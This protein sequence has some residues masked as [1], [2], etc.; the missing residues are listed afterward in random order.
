MS[1]NG[2]S[3]GSGNGGYVTFDAITTTTIPTTLKSTFT[4]NGG[5][6]GT[7]NGGTIVL[8]PY[9][10]I[11]LGNNAGEFAVSATSGSTGGNGGSITVEPFGGSITVDNTASPLSVAVLGTTGNGGSITLET[12]YSSLTFNGTA[13]QL[14]ANGGT[15]SGNG[16]SITLAASVAALTIGTGSAGNVQL[17]AKAP[18]NGNGGSISITDYYGITVNSADL[19]VLAGP[20]GNGN[21][22]TIALTGGQATLT[23]SF[24]ANGAGNGNGGTINF[25]VGS[26]TF[27]STQSFT[28]N[29]LGTG[30]G[31]NITLNSTYAGQTSPLTLGANTTLQA[32]STSGNGGTIGI[33]AASQPIAI[34]GA[35]V[36]VTAGS[37]GTGGTIN[38][39]ATANTIT[40]AGTLAADGRGSGSAGVISLI[41]GSTSGTMTLDNA[42]IS[43]S[44]DT[45]GNGNGNQITIQNAGPISVNSTTFD[46]KGGGTGNGGNVNITITGTNTAP[47]NVAVAN[48][49]VNADPAQSGMG[50]KI[51]V[52]KATGL[53]ANTP[54]DITTNFHVDAGQSAGASIFDGSVALNTD[55]NGDPIVCQQFKNTVTTWPASYWY[56]GSRPTESLEVL[57]TYQHLSSSAI[58]ALNAINPYVLT[59]YDV[60]AADAFL[61]T[62][63]LGE[64][65][66]SGNNVA[67]WYN[68]TENRIIVLEA[69]TYAGG[70]EI[71]K[72]DASIAETARHE[73]GHV[74]DIAWG[75]VAG[76]AYVSVIGG[77]QQQSYNGFVTHDFRNLTYQ[78]PA[79]TT[80]L[81]ACGAG[82]IFQGETDPRFQTPICPLQGDLVGLNNQQILQKIQAYFTTLNGQNWFETWAQE[83]SVF[84]GAAGNAS[85]DYYFQNYFPCTKI[86]V[87]SLYNTG[88]L[89]PLSAYPASCTKLS[90]S[91]DS[92]A[93]I[94]RLLFFK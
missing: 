48:F 3:G 43:A 15:T 91:F 2:S 68:Y 73:A 35:G 30:A 19:S 72:S 83:F 4:A 69:V 21:G 89:A 41:A 71:I 87:Q 18:G 47:A 16:G 80:L 82:A 17:F 51:A 20:T 34:T 77:T 39:T 76:R 54:I 13:S 6:S 36:K 78:A 75:A 44:G 29:S 65:G 24:N 14:T 31:G 92:G 81:P 45:A 23:G 70:G 61:V 62:S 66:S 84:T 85:V 46:A 49:N 25:Q 40:V 8:D 32:T 55:A 26:F 9:S 58:T 22:G 63:E 52:N 60:A 37:N 64:S 94:V 56:C 67:G 90:R 33:T 5:G 86:Y 79:Y 12:F 53:N 93:G 11:K 7:G 88:E 57:S 42:T 1:A 74:T 10:N 28:A 59:F 27:N 38:V 50:G